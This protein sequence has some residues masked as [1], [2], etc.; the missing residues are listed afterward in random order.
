MSTRNINAHCT[1]SSH[2]SQTQ[3]LRPLN[4]RQSAHLNGAKRKNARKKKNV[5]RINIWNAAKETTNRTSPCSY[6]RLFLS[7]DFHISSA[8]GRFRLLFYYGFFYDWMLIVN[9]FMCVVVLFRALLSLNAIWFPLFIP[10][11]I[12]YFFSSFI[13]NEQC[14]HDV[15]TRAR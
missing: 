14:V 3:M 15:R 4:D 13:C 12:C 2:H 5:M 6:G 8:M 9:L 1:H 11:C 10:C 7:A